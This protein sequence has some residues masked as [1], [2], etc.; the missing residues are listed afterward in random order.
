MSIAAL[1]D[2]MTP[3]AAPGRFVLPWNVS[4]WT[5]K[6]QLLDW[7]REE[8]DALHW[9]NPE[10]VARL[11]ARP[12]WQPRLQLT[13]LIYSYALGVCDAQDASDLCLTDA[14]LKAA[15]P[16]QVPAA[17]ALIRFRVENQGLIR[18]ALEQV[19]KRVLRARLDLGD[20]LI[21]PGYKR[22]LRDAAASRLDAARQLDR[23][24]HDE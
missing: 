4:E 9:D 15:F 2:P 14:G 8:L 10:L 23:C 20:S 21:P 6:A 17:K 5:T 3:S 13:V 22:T 1:M 19:L 24:R 7:V 11:R 16:S 18:W 12:S